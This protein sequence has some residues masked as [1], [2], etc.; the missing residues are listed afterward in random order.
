MKK[1]LICILLL[2]FFNISFIKAEIA[3]DA[4]NY[5]QQYMS[6]LLPFSCIYHPTCS[7]YMK[8]AVTY[9]GFQG[10]LMGVNR[11]QSCNLWSD[12][13]IYNDEVNNHLIL[14]YAQQKDF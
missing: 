2:F 7:G 8:E 14:K 10:L 4:V 13:S 12:K 3:V 5:Y 6:P 1:R 11:I 9:Y